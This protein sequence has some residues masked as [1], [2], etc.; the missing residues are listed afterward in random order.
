MLA[1]PEG[2]PQSP[3]A[4]ASFIDIA[5]RHHRGL[6]GRIT[7][8]RPHICPFEELLRRIPPAS[9]VLDVG[10]GVGIMSALAAGPGRAREVVGFDV[11]R[12]AIEVARGATVVEGGSMSFLRLPAGEFP[13][14]QFDVVFCIDVIHHVPRSAQRSFLQDVCDRVVP[15]GRLIL[16]DISPR[17]RWKALANRVHD[18]IMARQWVNY[19]RESQVEAQLRDAGGEVVESVRLDRLWYSHFLI[20]WQRP[21][22]PPPH[23]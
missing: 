6:S 12:R 3:R 23:H 20:V 22:E 1:Y 13:P 15:G 11:S 19:Q 21:T 5:F 14:G 18:L 9:S 2:M 8:L 17:P 16:K 4:I 10:C 7:R